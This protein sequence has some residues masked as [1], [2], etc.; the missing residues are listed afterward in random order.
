MK[1]LAGKGK[2]VAVLGLTAV[3][4]VSLAGCESGPRIGRLTPKMPKLKAEVPESSHPEVD[5][6]TFP[7]IN[8]A[9]D[10]PSVMRSKSQIEAIE[11]SLEE[12]GETHVKQAL[13]RIT[14]KEPEDG[15]AD[16]AADAAGDA[17]AEPQGDTPA[18]GQSDEPVKPTPTE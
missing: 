13:G 15:A 6:E 11:E 14:G 1:I 8:N 10:R 9:P 12:E 2:F 16:F 4:A 3:L 7:N 18:P 5:R 17:T